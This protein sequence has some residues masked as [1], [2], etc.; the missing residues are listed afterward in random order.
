[1]NEFKIANRHLNA[2]S[3]YLKDEIRRLDLIDTYDMIETTRVDGWIDKFGKINLVIKS[4]PYYR[5]LDSMSDSFDT[6]VGSRQTP[7]FPMTE[8]WM[9]STR[10]NERIQM[11]ISEFISL[12]A[13]KYPILDFTNMLKN[14]KVTIDFQDY[15]F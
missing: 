1:M 12:M 2:L 13:A 9:N 14:P 5:Y 7:G 15:K 6:S 3:L 11:I 8:N 10:F 4:M